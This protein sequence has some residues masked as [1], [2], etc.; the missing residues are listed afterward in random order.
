MHCSD[1]REKNMR[2]I[3]K[4]VFFVRFITHF[5]RWYDHAAHH[6]VKSMIT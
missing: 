5:L 3:S 2:N 4:K 6:G 1:P